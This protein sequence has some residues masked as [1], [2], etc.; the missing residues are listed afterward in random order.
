LFSPPHRSKQTDGRM[1]DETDGQKGSFHPDV[2]YYI[3]Y[4]ISLG[5]RPFH[6]SVPSSIPSSI[7]PSIHPRQRGGRARALL[8]LQNSTVSGNCPFCPIYSTIG[9]LYIKA[10]MVSICVDKNWAV[11]ERFFQ[12]LPVPCG[13]GDKQGMAGQGGQGSRCGGPREVPF[14]LKKSLG[15]TGGPASNQ[16]KIQFF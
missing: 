9:I 5:G 12:S 16:T 10:N 2:L 11:P 1:D 7:R 4:I 13:A 3:F 14:L 6:P 8:K 15:K